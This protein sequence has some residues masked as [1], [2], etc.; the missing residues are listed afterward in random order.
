MAVSYLEDRHCFITFHPICLKLAGVMDIEGSLGSLIYCLCY[1]C[2]ISQTVLRLCFFC[3][4]QAIQ[5]KE[6]DFLFL[7]AFGRVLHL[8][9]V[10]GFVFPTHLHAQQLLLVPQY[11][12]SK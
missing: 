8:R 2:H 6:H 4:T 1:R 12:K 10:Y 11:K 3:A 5:D 9:T 7:S